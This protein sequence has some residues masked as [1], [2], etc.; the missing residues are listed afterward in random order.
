MSKFTRSFLRIPRPKSLFGI[1][2]L[3]TG[4]ELISL[5]LIF[6]KV[7]GV[8]GFLA[9]LTGYQL[10]LLQL[11]TYV[12]TIGVLGLLIYLIPHIRQQSPFECLALAWLYMIDALLNAMFTATFGID[13]YLAGGAL[14]GT[15][16]S[17]GGAASG[18]SG[19]MDT[20]LGAQRTMPQGIAG[21]AGVAGGIGPQETAASMALITGFTLIR[22]YFGLVVMAYARQVLHKY[23]QMM[24]LE[25]PGVDDKFGPF[26]VDLPDGEGRKGRLGRVMVSMLRNYWIDQREGGEWTRGH[27]RG[28]SS[29]ATL[30]DEV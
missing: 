6:N 15:R 1:I 11:T 27:S 10:S 28:A 12:Y 21:S 7:T 14:G 19:M 22:V 30:A 20:S 25:G 9:I 2:G 8:Y 16:S 29:N 3:R 5:A 18:A 17:M 26:A 4:T 24:I 23:M 13:W